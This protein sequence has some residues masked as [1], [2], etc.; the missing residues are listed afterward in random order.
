MH[1]TFGL[2][3]GAVCLVIA[4]MSQRAL[5]DQDRPRLAWAKKCLIVL[6]VA[7]AGAGVTVGLEVS[8]R[9]GLY[10][11]PAAVHQAAAFCR[12]LTIGLFLALMLS[13]QWTGKKPSQ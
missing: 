11:R 12:G 9:A 6:V 1:D 5:F 8:G 13:G 4:L 7:A 10:V 3:I 2:F